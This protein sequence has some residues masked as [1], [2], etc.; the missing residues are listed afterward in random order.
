M[1]YHTSTMLL[2]IG[3]EWLNGIVLHR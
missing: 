1:Q 2:N 3:V